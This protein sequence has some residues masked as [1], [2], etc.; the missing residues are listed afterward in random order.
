[1]KRLALTPLLLLSLSACDRPEN[2]A[3]IRIQ[4]PAPVTSAKPVANAIRSGKVSAQSG[5]GWGQPIPNSINDFNCYAVFVGG[6]EASLRDKACTKGSG[7]SFEKFF[8][9]HMVGFNAAGTT[10]ELDLEP[11]V[12][13]NFYV[14]GVKSLVACQSILNPDA[15]DQSQL[16]TPVLVG[17]K[18]TDLVVGNNEISINASL[19]ADVSTQTLQ[20][21]SFFGGSGGAPEKI[22]LRG[23]I[24]SYDG[25]PSSR[26]G[27]ST[28][29]RVRLE[30]RSNSGDVL[31]ESP[32]TVALAVTHLAG[33]AGIFHSDE[34]C[35]STEISSTV[36]SPG[37]RY[38]DVFFKANATNGTSSIS[39]SIPSSPSV[40]PAA[41]LVDSAFASSGNYLRFFDSEMSL[42]ANTCAEVPYWTVDGAGRT[43]T[44]TSGVI[45]LSAFDLGGGIQ[46]LGSLTGSEYRST[47][48]GSAITSVGPT[49]HTGKFGFALGTLARD[50]QIGAQT[51][52]P[53]LIR[54]N[55]QPRAAS[56]SLTASSLSPYASDCTALTLLA[57]N[58]TNTAAD[59]SGNDDSPFGF[60]KRVL[61]QIYSFDP[62]ASR[63]HY[64]ANCS[65]PSMDSNYV[66]T[67][68]S[69]S[70][71]VTYYNFRTSGT[72]GIR[73]WGGSFVSGNNEALLAVTPQWDPGLFGAGMGSNFGY[74]A[75]PAAL[76]GFLNAKVYQGPLSAVVETNLPTLVPNALGPS[77]NSIAMT[78]SQSLTNASLFGHSNLT[79][80]M[81]FKPTSY[82]VSSNILRII[83]GL[84][85]DLAS[86]N[87][88]AS[89]DGSVI[90][91]VRNSG[92]FASVS[93]LL[94]ITTGAWQSLLVVRN[95]TTNSCSF[96]LN[97][98]SIGSTPCDE[99]SGITS[100]QL[101]GTGGG[102]PMEI[103]EF[104]LIDRALSTAEIQQHTNYL[105]ARYPLAN[106]HDF[107]PDPF[108]FGNF[109]DF[110]PMRAVAG[111]TTA[112][113]MRIMT[114]S[115]T[116]ATV[117]YQI[118][119]GT[120]NPITNGSP[121]ILYLTNGKNLR[122]R[123]DG[124]QGSQASIDLANVSYGMTPT[125]IEGTIIGT[126]F[127]P[128]AVSPVTGDMC[129]SGTVYVG[130][131]ASFGYMTT[132]AGCTNSTT[133]VC[134]GG[135]DALEK[136][137][138]GTGG[139]QNLLG[140]AISAPSNP[141]GVSGSIN[142]PLIAYDTNIGTGNAAR[143]CED[144]VYAG[145][146]DWF[147]P[148]K[149]ELAFMFCKANTPNHNPSL[150]PNED[151]ACGTTLGGKGNILPGFA[152]AF[153][154][155]TSEYTAAAAYAQNFD[156]GAQQ[157]SSKATTTFKVRCM[158]RDS[159]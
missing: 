40:L 146:N 57:R 12:A 102:L 8:F 138:Q 99:A 139:V 27:T 147:L 76:S 23:P 120:W 123:V 42:A 103:G 72:V 66:L 85:Y 53:E 52:P 81:L 88:G 105:M 21:C 92:A 4:L 153:Y 159:L 100:F 9:H 30:L 155:S 20:G 24:N 114:S 67:D 96:F 54:V 11:G 41:R 121:T 150:Y 78:A 98:Y 22:E 79:F 2:S 129:N 16:S 135:T 142:T 156:T 35:T 51:S 56:L 84:S 46:T 104:F 145:F 47:C 69:S 137:W 152:A 125:P 158:R 60:V 82:T 108:A 118:N 157:N 43:T 80:G 15:L 91:G 33:T 136:S 86:V 39:V 110:S 63:S 14:L 74:F 49:G 34:S 95:S 130:D 62:N 5:G 131:L 101:G 17:T 126:V 32:L 124:P 18:T 64:D 97:G 134:A 107:T 109:N 38:K 28:C 55:V 141:D 106:I 149:T 68:A 13:R 73:A 119:G 31:L 48:A 61:A 122:F 58:A 132:P 25:S 128:C 65:T 90:L 127:D 26:L 3:K 94:P 143:Y 7:A 19:A 116:G 133:P 10:L 144:M 115:M 111:I 75:P 71:A 112:M 6:P 44:N 151:L 154:W 29:N 1:M 113:E 117:Q 36:V 77:Y 140:G 89:P 45:N 70:A 59:L 93:S 148:S 37:E 50:F 83:N 87:T